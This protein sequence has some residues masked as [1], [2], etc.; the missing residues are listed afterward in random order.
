[1]GVRNGWPWASDLPSSLPWT[2]EETLFGITAACPFGCGQRIGIIVIIIIIIMTQELLQ[3]T[4]AEYKSEGDV[5]GG[6]V[7]IKLCPEQ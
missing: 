5:V 2:K 3:I 7:A 4:R 1:M 6:S